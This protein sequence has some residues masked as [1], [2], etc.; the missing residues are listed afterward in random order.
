[1]IKFL[2]NALNNAAKHGIWSKVVMQAIVWLS[3]F[4]LGG[5]GV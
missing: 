1:M 3:A 2:I 5:I 4:V